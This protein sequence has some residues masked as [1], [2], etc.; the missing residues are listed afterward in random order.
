[1]S[2]LNKIKTSIILILTLLINFQNVNSQT[3]FGIKTGLNLCKVKYDDAE[4]DNLISPYKKLKPGINA[5]LFVLKDLNKIMTVGIDILY[6]Q[7]GLKYSQPS[8]REGKNTMNYIEIPATG[9]LNYH[10]N[11]NSKMSTYIGGYY[12]Y[13]I[14]GK[15]ISQDNY[16]SIKTITNV[17]FNNPDWEYNRN[18]AGILTGLRFI[19]EK[20]NIFFDLRYTHSML[21]SSVRTADGVY[22]RLFTININIK[23]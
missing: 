4:T 12:A 11:R 7:K 23:L 6:T 21:T 2:I 18:D 17:D 20:R 3:K 19:Q 14:S 9:G 16:T 8:Y 13:W 5:G 10:F 22:N 15:Y 1:M